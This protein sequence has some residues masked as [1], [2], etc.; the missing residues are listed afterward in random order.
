MESVLTDIT[1]KFANY[2]D[3]QSM[4]VSL[5]E[6]L[7]KAENELKLNK[8]L[9]LGGFPQAMPEQKIAKLSAKVADLTS[10]LQLFLQGTNLQK[11]AI[12]NAVP[13]SDIREWLVGFVDPR[14]PLKL[15]INKG[16]FISSVQRLLVA[17]GEELYI[18]DSGDRLFTRPN[19][20]PHI[21]KRGTRQ[22]VSFALICL[23]N[24]SVRTEEAAD[25]CV[26]SFIG[27]V[28]QA[29]QVARLDPSVISLVNLSISGVG[30]F[31]DLSHLKS[32]NARSAFSSGTERESRLLPSTTRNARAITRN[33]STLTIQVVSDRFIDLKILDPSSDDIKL[34]SIAKV[35]FKRG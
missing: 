7:A 35:P 12:V 3:P 4:M 22:H 9:Q 19:S 25:E 6:K 15:P 1:G 23:F 11:E 17:M 31:D 21:V 10:R 20:R 29:E 33:L 5:S 24:T 13:D 32:I 26:D 2:L 28:Q 18:F 30:P 27:Y 14:R 34:K 8:M 16:A